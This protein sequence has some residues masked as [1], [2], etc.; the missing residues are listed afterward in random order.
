MN[1]FKVKRKIAIKLAQSAAKVLGFQLPPVP[2]VS[3]IIVNHQNRILAVQ[4]TYKDGFALPGGGLEGGE[5]FEEGLAREVREETGLTIVS[6]KL[7]GQYAFNV[8]YP[9][10]NFVYLCTVKGKITD[11][12][13]GQVSYHTPQHLLKTLIY[14]DN[15]A[16]ITDFLSDSASQR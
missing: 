10:I 3:A 1:F 15:L 11:S 14:Q 13:E 7:F 12:L 4:L 16:A 5:T 9:T 2:S 8:E 6:S